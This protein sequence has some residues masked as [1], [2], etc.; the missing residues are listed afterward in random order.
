[1]L[2][3]FLAIPHLHDLFGRDEHLAKLVLK[4]E[5]LRTRAKRFGHLVFEAGV[6]VDDVPA[7]AV[8]LD[9]NRTGRN[10]R[11]SGN[12]LLPN[13]RK[14]GEILVRRI[15]GDVRWVLEWFAIGHIYA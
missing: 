3:T 4:R 14:A 8:G 7:H 11:L 13:G 12:F 15:D 9:G 1:L 10:R 2:V 6:G 5:S